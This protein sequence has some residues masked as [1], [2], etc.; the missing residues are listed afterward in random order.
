MR[1]IYIGK[2]ILVLVIHVIARV[3]L[4]SSGLYNRTLLFL[5]SQVLIMIYFVGNGSWI[6]PPYLNKQVSTVDEDRGFRTDTKNVWLFN[7]L[8]D[9]NERQDLSETEPDK[10]REMLDKLAQYQKTAVPCRYPDND[11]R[12]DPKYLGGFWGPWE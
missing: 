2:C 5:L 11:R 7:I 10:L 6:P 8:K 12:A 4:I 1:S 9:P 3:V